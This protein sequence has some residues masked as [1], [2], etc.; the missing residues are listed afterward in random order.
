MNIVKYHTAGIVPTTWTSL[1]D[2]FFDNS[3]NRG[4]FES[5]FSPRA[6]VV[7][8][9]KHFEI[10]LAVPGMK[11]EDFKIELQDNYLTVSGVR[12]LDEERKNATH[13]VQEMVYGA[14]SRTFYLPEIVNTTA[15]TATYHQGMLEIHVPKDVKKVVKHSIEVK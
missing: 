4:V 7:E 1:V 13:H 11:K 5:T 14:F 8:T 3:L 2:R 15:V 10:L 12:K 9:E 6:D